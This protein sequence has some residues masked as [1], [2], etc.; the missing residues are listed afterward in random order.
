LTLEQYNEYVLLGYKCSE[1]GGF[2]MGGKARYSCILPMSLFQPKGIDMKP[3]KEEKKEEMK[4][5]IKPVMEELPLDSFPE[6]QLPN[7]QVG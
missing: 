1:A 6:F 2:L 3:I 4:E 5:E 7:V